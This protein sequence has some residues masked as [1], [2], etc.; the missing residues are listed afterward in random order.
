MKINHSPNRLA[1]PERI[2]TERRRGSTLVVVAAMLGLLAVLGY[3]LFRF[4]SQE[5]ESALYFS[6]GGKQLAAADFD[7]NVYFDFAL[8][9]LISGPDAQYPGSALAKGDKSLV[10]TLVGRDG[11]PYSGH[12]IRMTTDNGLPIVD[13][14]GDGSPDNPDLLEINHSAGAN[15]GTPRDVSNRPS[16][17][18]NYTSPDINSQFLAHV[19]YT[20]DDKGRPVL[21]VIPSFHRPQYLRQG[22]PVRPIVNPES[23]ASTVAKVLHPHVDHLG[24]TG[25][26]MR[27]I[28]PA[29]PLPPGATGPYPFVRHNQGVWDMRVWAGNAPYA[30]GDWV[31]PTDSNGWSYRCTNGG[32]S[33]N[34]EPTWPTGNGATITETGGVAWE[35][36]AQPIPE[37][38]ADP[39]GSGIK[40]A[41]Y[42]DLGFPSQ[43]LGNNRKFVPLFA[44]KVVDADGL[45][46][47]NAHGLTLSRDLMLGSDPY[48]G[49]EFIVK[50]HQGLSPAAINLLWLLTA[51]PN[52]DLQTGD[53][54]TEVFQEL[55]DFFGHQPASAVEAANMER[56]LSLIGRLRF[57]GGEVAEAYP[58]VF[59]EIQRL[60]N[61][62][63]PADFPF[64]GRSGIDDDNNRN[65]GDAPQTATSRPFGSPLDWREGG[66]VYDPTGKL[67]LFHSPA[68][69]LNIWPRFAGVETRGQV[70][71]A[72]LVGNNLMVDASGTPILPGG[73]T[74]P[75]LDDIWE[76]EL[77]P[78][79]ADS[80]I[81]RLL[82]ISEMFFLA[83]SNTDRINVG[84]SSR[85]EKLFNWHLLRNVRATQI[86]Q[87]FTAHSS[88]VQAFGMILP[89]PT[90]AAALRPHEVEEVGTNVALG[91]PRY[92]FP[93]RYPNASAATQ[94]MRPALRQWLELFAGDI[95]ANPNALRQRAYSL[96]HYL[97]DS[98][99]SLVLRPLTEH[100]GT[101]LDATVIHE[102][103]P[104]TSI[105]DSRSQEYFARR[106]RQ[107]MA[108]D[109]YVMLYTFCG[110][111]DTNPLTTANTVT[112][113]DSSNPGKELRVL[114]DDV[115]LDEMAQFAI[116]AVNRLD[117]DLVIDG[118]EFDRN[119]QDGWNLDDDP[120]T[121]DGH[122]DRGHVYG[123]EE[124]GLTFSEA[125]AIRFRQFLD[126]DTNAP[127]D[128]R[129]TEF[130]DTQDRYYS[131]FGFRNA[132]PRPIS[133]KGN[134][135]IEVETADGTDTW[136]RKLTMLEDD[137]DFP[138]ASRAIPAGGL[139]T[140]KNA[141]DAHNIDPMTM[142]PR[143]SHVQL[144]F[145]LPA[146]LM[147][148]GAMPIHD[149][150][151]APLPRGPVAP[152]PA[153]LGRSVDLVVDDGAA[154]PRF[155]L[156]GEKNGTPETVP[157]GGLLND[158]N[159]GSVK[160][161]GGGTITL[162]LYRRAHPER[163]VP[164]GNV[165]AN[166][167]LDNPWIEVD[168]FALTI[169]QGYAEV[170][171][172]QKDDDTNA[173]NVV[174]EMKTQLVDVKSRE[175]IEPLRRTSTEHPN[176]EPPHPNAPANATTSA[177]HNLVKL[178]TIGAD[179]Q[180]SGDPA[181]GDRFQLWQLPGDRDFASAIELLSVPLYGPAD[182]TR[183]LD[184]RGTNTAGMRKFLRPRA[185]GAYGADG[186][187]GEAR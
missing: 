50:S 19:G 144:D 115:Q 98:T 63:G 160:D 60:V 25:V 22:G 112:G 17:N 146:N 100:P 48:G 69:T 82:E 142:L 154:T 180:T 15:G 97:D 90:S 139:F 184:P 47:L 137:P 118:F 61:A 129:V 86:R 62:I 71:W 153:D 170:Q 167:D 135:R 178:N 110:G 70:S 117:R 51:D 77:D 18:P 166:Y 1:A 72:T 143:P 75:L 164:G 104:P 10:P 34:I 152:T 140:I 3:M 106:E 148:P 176:A 2:P 123:V 185:I 103:T 37:Y 80:S 94:P 116:N 105:G 81:D 124:Q 73:V 99:G 91:E 65:Y 59:G 8:W 67:R 16:I 43:Q 175:R 127:T 182:L 122:A 21:V 108:R 84:A 93:K 52:T 58:G 92:R 172:T 41:V 66:T 40:D 28:S 7:P 32:N 138:T 13:Q 30:V 57:A 79:F 101:E 42:I 114:Y 12:G 45:A 11:R 157:V 27:F 76:I 147:G 107:L 35:A 113:P 161:G 14:N 120:Y 132:S 128:H 68:N 121:D 39:S 181:A 133:F 89:T 168:R 6:G 29:E 179:N 163:A 162:R 46:N 136:I 54:A 159:I 95:D 186:Q 87:Q 125:L 49:G 44:Y 24:A 187:P 111:A 150:R 141:G 102:M 134:V 174:Q 131:F 88:D 130:D 145:D 83:A 96:N 173:A 26:E 4:T 9:Q 151:L 158:T 55:I 64:P 31:V 20:V 36:A 53:V 56:L 78:R 183:R 74:E 119:L 126:P 5:L 23:D 38:D 149:D 156:E 155:K 33:S 177:N 165:P 169:N 109:I 85:L 171:L